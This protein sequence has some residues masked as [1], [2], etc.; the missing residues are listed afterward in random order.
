MVVVA[1]VV[2][3]VVFIDTVN[4]QSSGLIHS[5]VSRGVTKV[6]NCSFLWHKIS[7]QTTLKQRKTKNIYTNKFVSSKLKASYDE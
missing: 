3:M 5:I 4:C 1:V 7:R 6:F 2:V